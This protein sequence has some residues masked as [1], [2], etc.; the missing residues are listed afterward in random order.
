MKNS[1]SFSFYARKVFFLS[2]I[3]KYLILWYNGLKKGDVAVK[4]ILLID[5]SIISL[6]DTLLKREH[7][8]RN[9]SHS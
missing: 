9:L 2:Y 4:E 7:N 5:K 3:E 6:S 1:G 8:E